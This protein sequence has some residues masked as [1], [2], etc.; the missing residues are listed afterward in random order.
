MSK[1]PLSATPEFTRRNEELSSAF[2]GVMHDPCAETGDV[3]CETYRK[4]IWDCWEDLPNVISLSAS[5]YT[6]VPG[7]V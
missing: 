1:I 7:H 4:S 6:V 2:R 3:L 5:Q